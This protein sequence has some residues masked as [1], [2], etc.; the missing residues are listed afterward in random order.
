M[1]VQFIRSN[2][3]RQWRLLLPIRSTGVQQQSGFE[4]NSHYKKFEL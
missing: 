4:E 2:V 3:A 1:L